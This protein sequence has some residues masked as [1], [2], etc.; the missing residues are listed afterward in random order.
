M[1]NFYKLNRHHFWQALVGG[2]AS[3]MTSPSQVLLG[4][5]DRAEAHDWAVEDMHTMNRWQEQMSSTAHQREVE[6][7]RK[8]GL[9]PILSGTGGSGASAGSSAGSQPADE[10][11]A[12]KVDVNSALEI[13]AK[14]QANKLM[15]AQEHAQNS[16]ADLTKAQ[17]RKTNAETQILGPKS[18][19]FDKVKEGLQ[20][21]ASA[22]QNVGKELLKPK[23]EIQKAQPRMESKP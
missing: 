2:A 18:F 23:Y 19:L 17:T 6:D 10:V 5:R 8:A 16:A 12:G 9:N 15:K 14:N 7:L 21:G 3:N 20:N 4:R 22:I 13:M 1:N 11:G